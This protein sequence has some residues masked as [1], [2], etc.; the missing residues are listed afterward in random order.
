VRRVLRGDIGIT[1]GAVLTLVGTFMPWVR[2]GQT[3]RT[4]YGLLGL[5]DRLEFAP[6]GPAAMAVKWWPLVPMLL[7]V[8]VIAAWWPRR[9]VA[10]GAAVLAGV[11]V[12]GM[13]FA[14]A[15]A[16]LP[17]L[18]GRLASI[19]GAIVLLG[20]AAVLTSERPRSSA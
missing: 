3:S 18:G 10:V 6:D 1:I 7:T 14:L 2:S 17:L 11:Y 20:A 15:K 9:P 19:A 13:A 8:S 16:P 4:S 5:V 12:C